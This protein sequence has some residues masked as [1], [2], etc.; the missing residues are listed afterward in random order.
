MK[1]H[2]H[3]KYDV[4]NTIGENGKIAIEQIKDLLFWSRLLNLWS[5]FQKED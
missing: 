5:G 1:A 4:P 2:N 3:P